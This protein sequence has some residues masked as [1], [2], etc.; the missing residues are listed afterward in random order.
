MEILTTLHQRELV[1]QGRRKAYYTNEYLTD[2]K[3]ENLILI[4]ELFFNNDKKR[5]KL[6]NVGSSMFS[7]ITDV[8]ANF[9]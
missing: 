9:V 6:F 4:S 7:T 8:I 5:A 2:V 3:N 1:A